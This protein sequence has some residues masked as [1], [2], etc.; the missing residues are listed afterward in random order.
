MTAR[1]DRPLPWRSALLCIAVLAACGDDPTAGAPVCA[2]QR[3]LTV[4]TPVEGA[5]LSGDARFAGAPIDYWALR[6][7]Q[8]ARLTVRMSSAE[9]DPVL[10]VF[11]PDGD[12]AAQAFQATDPGPGV[13]E[14][15][16]LV[17]A[18]AAGCNLIGA[19]TYEVDDEGAYSLLVEP[20]P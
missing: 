4:G 13:P 6:L 19:T 14:T 10:L 20:A 17:R 8:P 15:P 18:F 7:D 12:V 1:P 3:T 11:G 2:D 16:S 9:I 5:L